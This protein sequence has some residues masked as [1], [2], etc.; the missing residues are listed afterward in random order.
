M[1]NITILSRYYLTGLQ[2]AEGWKVG[3][4]EDMIYLL[5]DGEALA[6]WSIH[7]WPIAKEYSGAIQAEIV[8]QESKLSQSDPDIVEMLQGGGQHGQTS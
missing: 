7:A 6:R 8:R 2:R 5:R 3:M 1:Y 4:E